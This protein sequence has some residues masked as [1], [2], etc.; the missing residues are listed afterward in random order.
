MR[1]T[2]GIGSLASDTPV[3]STGNKP[4]VEDLQRWSKELKALQESQQEMDALVESADDEEEAKSKFIKF[5]FEGFTLTV[6]RGS[7]LKALEIFKADIET[8][9]VAIIDKFAKLGVEP[10]KEEVGDDD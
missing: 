3:S 8:E 10:F 4:T 7:M 1:G 6:T 2:F 9:R 5:R